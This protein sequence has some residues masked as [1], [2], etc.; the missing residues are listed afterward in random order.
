MDKYPLQLDQECQ[1]CSI[2]TRIYFKTG[3]FLE[4]CVTRKCFRNIP[5]EASRKEGLNDSD[6]PLIVNAHALL[7]DLLL[8]FIGSYIVSTA[9]RTYVA[10]DIY[11]RYSLK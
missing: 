10:V 3:I 5:Q 11:R 9:Q 8:S 6:I 7:Q 4:T 2:D 1:P